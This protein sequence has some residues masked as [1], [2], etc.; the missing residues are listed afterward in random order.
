[1]LEK[2]SFFWSLSGLPSFSVIMPIS[3]VSWRAGIG[4]FN[5]MKFKTLGYRPI[6]PSRVQGL[7]SNSILYCYL[8]MILAPVIGLITV[9]T[10]TVFSHLQNLLGILRPESADLLTDYTFMMV[11]FSQYFAVS[12]Y[13]VIYETLYILR[14]LPSVV[15][16][17]CKT[18]H[19][20]NYSIAILAVL[21][22]HLQRT[23]PYC[24]QCNSF[25]DSYF[26]LK[27]SGDVHPN[28]GPCHGNTFKFCQWNLDSIAVNDFVK[29]PLIEAYNS[30]YNYDIIALFETYLDSS[31]PNESISLTGFSKEIYRSDHPNDVKRGG[32]CLY[33]KYSL[34]IKQ[35]KDLQILDECIISELTIGRKKVF[36]V[37]VYRSPSQNA[38]SFYSFL[39]NLELIIQ[40]LKDKRPHY[41]ILTGD[42]NCRSDS[43]WVEDD[44]TKEGT[45]LSE[46]CDSYCLNQLI[47]EPTHIL[48]NSLSCIDLT[49]TDQPNLFVDSG[50][51]SSLYA[52]SHHQIVFGVVSLS[53]P[54]PPPY[55]GTVWEYDKA[56]IDMINH[57]L[58]SINLYEMFDGLDVNQAVGLFT[59]LYSCQ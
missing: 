53:V 46:L 23:I 24:F 47:E 28:P 43:W 33:F 42:F 57:D 35:R 1:M 18:C 8:F 2:L 12:I 45:K 25:F 48:G 7:F 3:L 44:V 19:T 38:E 37:V 49:I 31:I 15:T 56:N 58:S 26:H 14:K 9:I 32:V 21:L 6:S 11:K 54:R 29:I 10:V 5:S 36:F 52:K 55:K 30:V 13:F 20:A 16:C 50:V 34:A 22:L 4:L 39:E 41:I 59:T 51:H 27:L 40:N 17:F